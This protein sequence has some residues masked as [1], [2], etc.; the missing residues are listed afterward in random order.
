MTDL[1]HLLDGAIYLL[2]VAAS[3]AFVTMLTLRSL[4]RA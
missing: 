4:H 1:I 3:F 2:P